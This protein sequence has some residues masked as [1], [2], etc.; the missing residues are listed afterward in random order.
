MSECTEE[1]LKEIGKE[2]ETCASEGEIRDVITNAFVIFYIK[3]SFID[4]D[5]FSDDPLGSYSD[6]KIKQIDLEKE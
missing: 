4:V 2:N 3:S 1:S 6:I 5:I